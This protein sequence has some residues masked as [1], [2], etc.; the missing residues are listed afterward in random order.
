MPDEET[1]TPTYCTADDVRTYTSLPEFTEDDGEESP[2]YIIS[3]EQL[4]AKIVV[5]ERYIDSIAGYWQRAGGVTQARVFPR[6]EDSAY[7]AGSIPEAV[8]FATIE[9]VELMQVNMA[10]VDHGI[11]PDASPTTESISPR[12]RELMRGY[13]RK[14]GS[15]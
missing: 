8:K 12:A 9:Q 11:E 13:C 14:T 3:D 10:D 5:A 2:E 6:I 1:P 7:N 4:D 15:I